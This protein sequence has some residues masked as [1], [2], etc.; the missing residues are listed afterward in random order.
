MY[1]RDK[2][3]CSVTGQSPPCTEI[4]QKFLAL[5]MNAH[6]YTRKLHSQ[7]HSVTFTPVTLPLT[8]R[9]IVFLAATTTAAGL[10][11]IVQIGQLII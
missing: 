11:F 3:S 5:E 7:C 9:G 6:P 10:L 1:P 4:S 2:W 8:I